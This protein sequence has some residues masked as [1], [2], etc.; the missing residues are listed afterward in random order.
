MQYA[1]RNKFDNSADGPQRIGRVGTLPFFLYLNTDPVRYPL[2]AA[3]QIDLTSSFRIRSNTF[4]QI[5]QLSNIARR[6]NRHIMIGPT[7]SNHINEPHQ[8]C[9]DWK[10]EQPNEWIRSTSC[11]TLFCNPGRDEFDPYTTSTPCFHGVV[12]GF[13]SHKILIRGKCGA[14]ILPR[15]LCK[16]GFVSA[17]F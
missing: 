11:S 17:R 2:A 14:T 4:R 7:N 12:G 1:A 9:G 10:F 8:S 16:L 3:S 6:D 13:V 5:V 15:S